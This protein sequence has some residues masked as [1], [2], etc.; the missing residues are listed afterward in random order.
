MN[1][2]L[3]STYELGRQPFGL[4]SPAAW[5]RRA[6]TSVTCLDLSRET[7]REGPV[8]SADFIGFYVPMHTATRLAVGLLPAVRKLNPGAHLCFY[9]LYAPVNED[10]LRKL[11]AETILG[12][13]FE[14]GLVS[15]VERVRARRDASDVEP[16]LSPS[17]SN[18]RPEGRHY[19]QCGPV[20]SL[21]RQIFH[22]PDRVGL[23]ALDR[24]AHLHLP[25]G[26]QRVVGYTEA[27]HGCKHLCRHCPVVPVYGGQ[28]RIVQ[29]DVVLEDVR[30]QVAAGAEHITF[31]DPDFFN[32]PRHAMAIVT[33]LHEKH[34]N[35]TYDVTI[36]I[37]HLL[38]QA[39]LLRTLR[40]TGCLFVTSAA[41]TVDDAILARLDKAHTYADFVGVVELF[42][43]VGLTLSPTF[44]AF[45]P[46]TTLEGYCELLA[47][48]A[49][50][51]LIENIAPIQL[52]IRLLIPARSRLLELAEVREM[53]GPFDEAALVYPWA[54][55]DPRVDDL[56]QRIQALIRQ[57]K[58]K[59]ES[60]SIIFSRVWRLA[61]EAANLHVP[62]IPDSA[63]QIS[64][65]AIPYLTEPWYC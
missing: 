27:S 37:E 47:R 42:R 25:N 29:Q 39:Q 3:I 62:A 55:N 1:A 63:A 41:E 52:A 36:K 51:D 43:E 10:Y 18:G 23:P 31:G 4:A 17:Q 19:A 65:A 9:G 16:G 60:R 48:I 46:W 64:R 20:I 58:M 12:G 45:T 22:V 13:E 8:R 26:K 33:A 38:K 21:G 11:G 61:H 35:L 6:G 14:E 49:E 28:F 57:P 15:A 32:G 5:L 24:Y 30:R 2:L 34:P 56:C 7:L 44:V 50:L 59:G 54:H 40:D 53:V